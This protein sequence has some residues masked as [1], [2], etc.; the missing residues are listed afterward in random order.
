MCR[1]SWE[2]RNRRERVETSK[3]KKKY[4]NLLI[5]SFFVIALA[6]LEQKFCLNYTL[7]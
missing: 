1:V 7:G 6:F 5:N 4:H 2:F 3:Q